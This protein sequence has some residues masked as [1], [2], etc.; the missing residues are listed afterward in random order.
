VERRESAISGSREAGR[1]DSNGDAANYWTTWA[2]LG[3]LAA[4]VFLPFGWILPIARL[5]HARVT[6]RRRSVDAMRR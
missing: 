6:A 2:G 5:A 1:A 4:A 3:M